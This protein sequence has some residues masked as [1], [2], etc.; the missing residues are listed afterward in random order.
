MALDVARVR[1]LPLGGV[2]RASS[3]STGSH[4]RDVAPPPESDT[5][6]LRLFADVRRNGH[7]GDNDKM[8]RRRSRQCL[9]CSM[10]VAKLAYAERVV[11][12][13]L[14]PD[15][16]RQTPVMVDGADLEVHDD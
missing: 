4:V 1:A 12:L 11:D 3:L 2:G 16:P 7:Q 15:H 5:E 13:V 9:K 6:D 14:A 10:F 8:P